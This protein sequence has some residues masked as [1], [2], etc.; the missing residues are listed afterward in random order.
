MIKFNRKDY[1]FPYYISKEDKKNFHAVFPSL[2]LQ[3]I[4]LFGIVWK[5]KKWKNICEYGVIFSGLWIT[6]IY[7]WN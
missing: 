2:Y 7:E 6:I 3:R 1:P 5:Q 4:P